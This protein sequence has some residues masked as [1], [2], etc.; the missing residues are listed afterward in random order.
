MKRWGLKVA[1]IFGVLILIL[2]G[3]IALRI[4]TWK[5]RSPSDIHVAQSL[6]LEVSTAVAPDAH[7]SNTDL[8]KYRGEYLLAHATSPWHFASSKCR[9]VIRSSPDGKTWRVLSEIS[10]PNEDVRDPKLAEINGKLFL[11]FLRNTKKFEAE[12]TGTAYCVSDDGV[13]WTAP[14]NLANEGWL[15][16]RPKTFD[17]KTFYAPAYWWEHGKSM[18]FKTTDGINW[19][20]VGLIYSGDKN[21]ETAISFKPDGSMIMT[22]RLEMEPNRWGY[23]PEAHTLIGVA[24]PPYTDWKLSR[25]YETRLDG[26]YLFQVGERTYASGRRHVGGA[27]T[28]GSV[29]GAKR[30]S[31][32]LVEPDRL[33]FLSDLPSCGDTAYGGVVVENDEIITSYYTSPPGRDYPWI[34]GML[35]KSS[36]QLARFKK[37]ALEKLADEKLGLR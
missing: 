8:L 6:R 32:Y 36:I 4:L 30:T 13:T 2:L 28:M 31:L 3:A 35:S 34:L 18:L 26:P 17:G 9:L 24:S 20:E 10:V 15:W 37:S 14:Q 11:Y 23:H 22:A 27:R 7:H 16:W 25:S 12:P 1:A 19:S 5:Y 33:V 29:W 21:D